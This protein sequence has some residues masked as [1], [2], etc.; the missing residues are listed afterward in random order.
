MGACSASTEGPSEQG[1][2][3]E[4]RPHQP[5]TPKRAFDANHAQLRRCGSCGA[6]KGLVPCGRCGNEWYCGPRCQEKDWPVHELFCWVQSDGELEPDLIRP[7]LEPVDRLRDDRGRERSASTPKVELKIAPA[8]SLR[9]CMKGANLAKMDTVRSVSWADLIP[10]SPKTQKRIC[11]E[12]LENIGSN[13]SLH[14]AIHR[15]E[16]GG[17]DEMITSA[18]LADGG[19]KLALAGFSDAFQ[20]KKSK[21]QGHVERLSEA[22][23]DALNAAPP[24][25]SSLKKQVPQSQTRSPQSFPGAKKVRTSNKKVPKRKRASLEKHLEHAA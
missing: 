14:S 25:L 23:T 20:W 2:E 10:P 3:P 8:S 13:E 6:R 4:K 22:L 16:N 17:V 12:I 11:N 7:E 15:L 24:N 5:G 18:R 1:D 9:S 19:C 21:F